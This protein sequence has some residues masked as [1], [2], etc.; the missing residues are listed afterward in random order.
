MTDRRV[1]LT[2]R[3]IVSPLGVGFEDHWQA[4]VS[5]RSAV[6]HLPQLERLGLGTSRGSAVGAELLQPHLGRLPR[7]QQKLYNRP[8]LLAMLASTLAMEDAALAA[9]AGDPERFGVLLGVNVPCWD[10]GAMLRYVVEARSVTSPDT[11]DMARANRFCMHSINP[12]DF[13]LKTLPNLTAGHVAIAQDARGLCRALTEGPSGG[14]HAIGQASRMIAEGDLDVVLCGGADAQL[15]E[16]V[17]G[18][19]EGAD[20]LAADSGERGGECPGEG[21][22]VL[23]L[24]EE[25]RARGRGARIHA[26]LLAFAIA[27]GDGRLASESDPDAVARRMARVIEEAIAGTGSP[28]DVVSLHGDGAPGYD[29]AERRALTCVLGPRAAVVPT[30]AMKRAHGS[31]GAASAPIELLACSAILERGTVPNGTTRS[32]AGEAHGPFTRALALSIGMFGECSAQMVGR[33]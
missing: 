31:L 9:G 22:G 1:V 25:A 20:L 30:I 13:S 16:F 28:P 11:L 23:L 33:T 26:E 10:A 32:S 5:G 14:A 3:G 18:T 24:E 7:K 4:L 15:E 6:A 19:Y 29:D 21:A 12:L 17:Y 8:T 27:A 2:G